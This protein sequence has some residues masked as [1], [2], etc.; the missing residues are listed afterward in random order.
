MFVRHTYD[1]K[2]LCMFV[3]VSA[4]NK[5]CIALYFFFNTSNEYKQ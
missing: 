5:Y 2:Q 3:T 1:N 4:Q